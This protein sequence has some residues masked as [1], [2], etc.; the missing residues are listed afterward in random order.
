MN[1][2]RSIYR[3]WFVLKRK[4]ERKNEKKL[5]RGSVHN[6]LTSSL[7]KILLSAAGITMFAA[8]LLGATQSQITALG[9]QTKISYD[10]AKKTHTIT[11]TLTKGDNAFNAFKSFTLHSN[12]IANL[13]FPDN[14][15]NLLNFVRNKIN[16][17][18]TLNAVKNNKIGGNLYFLSSEGLIV[19]KN[20]VINAGAFYAMTPTKG[21]M[22]KF[23]GNE[24]KLDIGRVDAEIG[25]IVD[26]KISN[27]NAAYDYGVT[28]NPYGEIQIEG[29]INTINGIGLYAGG[30]GEG[31]DAKKKG[32]YIGKDAVLNSLDAS[33][34]SSV[35][36]V[37]GLSLPQ[38]TDIV[39]DGG[40]IELVSVQDNTH[41]SSKILEVLTGY[42]SFTYASAAT[43]IE[44]NGTINSRS[45]VS[46]TAYSSNGHVK[47]IKKNGDKNKF[48]QVANIADIYSTVVVDGTI[49]AEGDISVTAT[50]DNINELKTPN[51]AS[52][53]LELMGSGAKLFKNFPLNIDANVLVSKAHSYVN[54]KKNAK[55]EADGAIE[56]AATTN[57]STKAGAKTSKFVTNEASISDMA[58]LPI[59]AAG[60]NISESS[61]IVDFDGKAT[62]KLEDEKV[63]EA[64]EPKKSISI[65]AE[66]NS[67][68]SVA[69]KAKTTN[70]RAGAGI[71]FALGKHD[72]K[73]I[74]NIGKNAQL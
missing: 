25:Y 47:N 67:T 65:K 45:D 29:K 42:T 37:S 41:N 70:S 44:S 22:D 36:N 12:E 66:S 30:F 24:D 5:R 48:D 64:E 14:T 34:F 49:N 54:V 9:N 63:P 8:P 21:F 58:L 7:Q 4:N 17:E 57:T 23:I 59:I 35:V 15:K 27:H 60:V 38:A 55:L 46:L 56:V 19:G 40:S 72:N 39:E 3:K 51:F 61:A 13:K 2:C 53:A 68:L 43:R 20:G 71:A 33:G 6:L 26:R 28:I 32:L 11:T 1:F 10:D 52:L 50:S 69:S 31:S 62:S 18:G 74:L 16:V 73:A